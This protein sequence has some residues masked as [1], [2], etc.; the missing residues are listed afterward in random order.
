MPNNRTFLMY[1]LQ[2][3]DIFCSDCLVH[4]ALANHAQTRTILAFA[5]IPKTVLI[6]LEQRAM[7]IRLNVTSFIP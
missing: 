4:I 2:K 3:D 5:I 7:F 6:L 1:A